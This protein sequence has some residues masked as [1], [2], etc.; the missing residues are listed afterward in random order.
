[1]IKLTKSNLEL[2]DQLYQQCLNFVE[3]REHTIQNSIKEI[4][5]SLTSESK[6]SAGDKHE[7]GRAMLQLERE[8]LG[9]QLAEVEKLRE[10][11]SKIDSKSTCAIVGLGS[12]VFTSERN[13]YLS[14]SAGQIVVGPDTFIAISPLTPIGKLVLGRIKGDEIVFKE[15]AFT[16]VNVI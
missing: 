15:Q 5:E 1:M 6:S 2:K 14:I 12:V 7:T 16:I 9:H 3:N 13:Y 10:Q 8:K 4:Q 11:L